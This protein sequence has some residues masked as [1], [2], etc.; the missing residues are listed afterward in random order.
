MPAELLRS[1]DTA[2]ILG[3]GNVAVDCA[4]ILCRRVRGISCI[5]LKNI[6]EAKP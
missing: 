2:V 3:Q 5:H 1:H 4:R 6:Y